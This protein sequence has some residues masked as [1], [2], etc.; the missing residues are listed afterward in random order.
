MSPK[1][2]RL[3]T[4]VVTC[5][6][7]LVAGPAAKAADGPGFPNV[8]R[9]D[10][11]KLAEWQPLAG[12]GRFSL[13]GYH[14]GYLWIR[15]QAGGPQIVY[16]IS[17]PAAPAVVNVWTDGHHHSHMY[18]QYGDLMQLGGDNNFLDLSNMLDIR[19]VGAQ[20]HALSHAN[21][22][23]EKFYGALPLGYM[24]SS[25]YIC[26]NPVVIRN[27]QTDQTLASFNPPIANSRSVLTIGNLMLVVGHH[28]GGEAGVASYDVSNPANPILLDVLKA[29]L[30]RGYEPYVWGHHVVYSN[31]YNGDF[32]EAV[33]FSDPSDLKK[34]KFRAGGF[35]L[36]R[37]WQ[38][39]D[40]YGFVG[41][42]KVD[43]RTGNFTTVRQF[44]FTGDHPEMG[45]YLLPVGNLLIV[46][47]NNDPNSPRLESRVG[48]F[49]HQA[50]PDQN[51]PAVYY[52]NPPAG[53][54]NQALTTRIGLI[55]PETLRAETLTS[56]TILLRPVGGSP[57]STKISHSDKDIINIHPES[58]L[59][60]DTTYELVLPAG[61]IRDAAGNGIEAFGFNF[62]T[63]ETLNP[64][65]VIR[66]FTAATHPILPGNP[67]V[68]S[69]VANVSSAGNLESRFSAGDGSAFTAWGSATTFNHTYAIA[70]HY[71]AVAQVR[72]SQGEQAADAF[73]VTVIQAPVGPPPSASGPICRA[74][75]RIWVVN[76]DSN[77]VTAIDAN[78]LAVLF[79][80]PVGREPRSIASAP[81]GEIWVAC[82]Q[83]DRMDVLNPS[84]GVLL[85]SVPLIYG[86]APVGVVFSQ[87][88]GRGFISLEGSGAITE[89]HP[90]TRTLGAR[91]PSGPFPR[92]LAVSGDGSRMLVTR[93]IS[94][95]NH[96]EVYDFNTSPLT[97]RGVINLAKDVGPDTTSSG[98]GVPNYLTGIAI[99]PDGGSAWVTSKKDNTER[100]IF[101]EGTVPDFESTVRAIISK[102][103]LATGMEAGAQRVDL[104]NSDSPS[105]IAFSPLGDYLFVTLQGNN[106]VQIIDALDRDGS[107]K[108]L[109]GLAPQG[110]C[111]DAPS[112][113]LFSM[114]F[115]GRS[116]SAFDFE[117]FFS[118]GDTANLEATIS[119]VAVELLTTQQLAG[120]RVFYNAA[121]PRMSMDAYISC[122]SCHLDGGHDGRVWDFTHR[123]EGLRN[124]TDLRGRGGMAH[125]FVHWSANFD[126]IQDFEHD[127]R[128]PFGG[129]GFMSQA[130]FDSSTPLGT[131][132]AGASVEL[133]ALAA[134]VTSLREHGRSPHRGTDGSLTERGE[135][136]RGLFVALACHSCHTGDRFTDSDFA[137]ALKDV[138]TIDLGSG[139]RLGSFLGGIDTPTLRGLWHTGPYLHDGSAET[140][141]DVL[142][143]R[144]FA[145]RHGMISILDQEQLASLTEYL[146]QLDDSSSAALGPY[147][148][149]SGIHGL[150]LIEAENRDAALGS[151]A[152]S[153]IAGAD[154]PA[155]SGGFLR[156][157]PDIGAGFDGSLKTKGPRLDFRI[158]FVKT[159]IH[160]I[161]LR[162]F[163]TGG[164][165]DS[166]HVGLNGEVVS[167]ADRITGFALNNW[168]WSKTTMDTASATLN[169]QTPGVHNVHVWMREDG[170][171]LD[172]ILLST[173]ASYVPSGS[174]PEHSARAGPSPFETW[175]AASIRDSTKRGAFHDP[176][177]DNIPNLLERAFGLDPEVA[178]TEGL[179]RPVLNDSGFHLLYRRSLLAPDVSLFPEMNSGLHGAW[180][181]GPTHIT[182]QPL[183]REGSVEIRKATLVADPQMP[184]AFMRLKATTP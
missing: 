150:V 1:P 41:N 44:A 159:G 131:P 90:A 95:E 16:D 5:A 61:G 154:I 108:H 40:D 153:W 133:D 118:R 152:H 101:N 84:N 26:T 31:R 177:R 113:R 106:L 151:D 13:M 52:H 17:D 19:N 79:E 56:A 24:G 174:G 183:S 171:R 73:V 96:G 37:Y 146:L 88:T 64:A 76:P 142:T 71:T 69:V 112:G 75:G 74:D 176:D 87:V 86:D 165:D 122:A 45:E 43:M 20:G 65:P 77:T 115:T 11:Q 39:Q 48:I 35:K 163:A 182:D 85:A 36:S 57:V 15:D 179:P 169:I 137:P 141:T 97:L 63:G 2:N 126:E 81:G 28:G 181:G 3:L 123:G 25:G 109:T 114:N 100:G 29:G 103:D 139:T 72:D 50:A 89:I 62:S 60:D 121:D 130:A 80:V 92:A 110:V 51:P 127:I 105:A 55:I 67:T 99:S 136:G 128:G 158:E 160:H 116:V 166:C 83:S 54:V 184:S 12:E 132:K 8:A 107:G 145:D 155:S 46:G 134:Y 167:S 93:F 58:P 6:F 111:Y 156:A 49:A 102:I 148:Q 180:L 138:G 129:S 135:A 98:R 18:F 94:P 164:N 30:G 38:F 104:D 82:R 140:L 59:L 119:T 9:T 33:D 144:N 14:R 91:L 47:E 125:G 22:G 21:C 32:L 70:G 120:K 170:F 42:L 34:T 147:R 175:A 124:T 143:T 66:S 10:G 161:W 4:L 157:E 53:A 168:S 178:E 27:I 162:G 149:D 23:G 68:F 7:A 78:T 172:K 117:G 173:D